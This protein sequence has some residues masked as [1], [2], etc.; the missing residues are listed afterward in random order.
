MGERL[1]S[2]RSDLNT[3][4]NLKGH[5]RMAEQYSMM[6]QKKSPKKKAYLKSLTSKRIKG[7]SILPEIDDIS[8]S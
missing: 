5:E 3:K 8:Y 6:I 4:M 2:M 7:I 1:S